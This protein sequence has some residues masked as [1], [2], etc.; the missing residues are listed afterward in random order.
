MAN[1]EV[2][3]DRIEP[4]KKLG[5]LTKILV[6]LTSVLLLLTVMLA[7]LTY[8]L[9][10]GS[11]SNSSIRGRGPIPAKEM[12]EV[13]QEALKHFKQYLLSDKEIAARHK[14]ANPNNPLE[15]LLEG[16]ELF[17]DVP[18]AAELRGVKLNPI[19]RDECK[20]KYDFVPSKNVY[21]RPPPATVVAERYDSQEGYYWKI[22][23]PATR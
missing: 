11:N 6:V 3:M 10:R 14:P 2:G 20:V 8:T 5:A 13:R 17:G 21:A 12:A 15:A 23:A 19:S 16:L 18:A 7:A 22:V 4:S 9:V 1:E